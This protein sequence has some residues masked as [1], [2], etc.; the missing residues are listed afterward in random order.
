MPLSCSPP[1]LKH[2]FIFWS[3][4]ARFDAGQGFSLVHGARG[5]VCNRGITLHD[6]LT[7]KAVCTE[8]DQTG[9]FP[10][11]SAVWVGFC[12]LMLRVTFSSCPGGWQFDPTSHDRLVLRWTGSLYWDASWA[13]GQDWGYRILNPGTPGCLSLGH[14]SDLL[15]ETDS[16]WQLEA[17]AQRLL[18]PFIPHSSSAIASSLWR[19]PEGSRAGRGESGPGFPPSL[20]VF[21]LRGMV[22]VGKLK[23]GINSCWILLGIELPLYLHFLYDL[24]LVP[25]NTFPY[26]R[27]RA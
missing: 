11:E 6:R 26:T 4:L 23:V 2:C 21:L 27:V 5:C 7:G 13:G 25:M 14:D 24:L 17:E 22:V 9:A 16:A 1:Q 12:I 8:A 15:S 20:S 3:A 10:W 19:L 18:T